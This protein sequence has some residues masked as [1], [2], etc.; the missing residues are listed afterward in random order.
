MNAVKRAAPWLAVAFLVAA[1]G[2]ALF[3][4][5]LE[6]LRWALLIAG[7]VLLVVSLATS[8]DELRG[9]LGRR[10]ARYGLGTALVVLL[11]L[12]VVV[13]ASAISL[14]HA[15]RWDLTENRRH[16]LSPQTIK[17]LQNLKAPVEAIAFFRSDTPGKRTAEDL[18]KQ[19]ASYSGGKFSWRM[20]DP[21]RAPGL[22]RRYGVESYGTVVLE[23]GAKSEKVLD[24]EEERLTNGLV[25]V[26]REAKSRVYVLKGHGEADIASAE[27]GGLSEAKGQLER[28]N[29]EVKDLTLA[30][31]A[32]VPDDATV[33][34]LAG[35]KTDLF[36]P[37]LE[38]I[39]AYLKRG[40][41][42]FVMLTPFQANGLRT[43]L[44][45]YG[46]AVDDDLV[47]EVNPI[48]RQFGVGP[49]VPVVTQYENHPITRDLGGLMTL[50][51]L[52]RSLG[53]EPKHPPGV[54]VQPLALTS[55]QSWG[56]T[57]RVAL[58]RG[59]AKP[60]P[61]DKKGPLP[62]AVA[63]NLDPQA[64]TA[65]D[66]AARP[67]DAGKGPGTAVAGDN[68]K[69]ARARVVVVGTANLATN[70]FLGAPGNRDFFL[71]AVSWLA[72]QEDQLSV[73]PKEPT[74]QPIILTSAQAQ[75]VFWL[76]V[77]ILP[78]AVMIVG[79]GVLV[80]RRRAT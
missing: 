18:L 32:Q 79:I 6:R 21:D 39:D 67:A 44:A 23:R 35:P 34:L 51:P 60:D 54:T 52:T 56:E 50:F 64:D 53:A 61:Q 62:V 4:P 77:A 59:E 71:N 55:A 70:Q 48:A 28:A 58:E 2:V 43:Y 38:A 7:A 45:K 73:R 46:F 68:R 20:E 41:G 17:L 65:R 57:D 74:R 22:A 8:V 76:P 63:A 11:A 49:E 40:G 47:I 3:T 36:P 78:L 16:S 26:S 30:R 24:A 14:R 1:A 37:E 27:R 29:Y 31:E 19:Y 25:K 10:T 9:F 12:G 66:A 42:V 80:Q 75:L 69:P 15:A 33:L 72:E 5:W 13:L